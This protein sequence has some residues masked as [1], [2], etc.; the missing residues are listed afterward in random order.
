M[1]R[2][3]SGREGESAESASSEVVEAAQRLFELGRAAWPE[4]DLE[5]S[6]F[7][8]YFARHATGEPLP[9]PAR[10]ADL[11]L[12]CACAYGVDGAFAAFE[13]ALAGDMA[14]AVASIDSSHAFVEEIL[15]ATRERILVRKGGEPAKIA[16]YAG[17]ASLRSWLRAVAVRCAISQRRRKA[18]QRHTPFA[19]END[20]RL[21][22]G[23][24]EFDYLRGRYKDVFEEAVGRAIE[25]LP[26]KQRMLLRLNLVD[27]MSVD[28]L[29]A[30]YKVGRST[31]ARWLANARHA[32][33]EQA[34]RELHTKLQLTSTE[35]ESLAGDMRSQLE[36]SILRLLAST[37]G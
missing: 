25:Q 8:R 7:E 32:L 28:K 11:Y 26:S 20:R 34:R 33:L 23:G 35:L 1:V 13:R 17:R 27:G 6:V 16:D 14:R 21:A 12:A 19:V 30:I 24:P 37:S 36:V 22:K 9:A 5:P 15:Q 18:E 10:A 3:P 2:V 4:V 31:A 29:A